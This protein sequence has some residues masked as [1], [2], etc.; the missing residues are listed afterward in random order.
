MHIRF[1]YYDQMLLLIPRCVFVWSLFRCILVF[2]AKYTCCT[3]VT[4]PGMEPYSKC[5]PHLAWY[6]PLYC[7][8]CTWH[9]RHH[10]PTLYILYTS[11]LCTRVNPPCNHSA[12]VPPIVMCDTF[13]PLTMQGPYPPHIL[14]SHRMNHCTAYTHTSKT[15]G[16]GR[17]RRLMDYQLMEYHPQWFGWLC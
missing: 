2:L 10:H 7:A 14:R 13:P 15:R 8:T 5:V 12:C 17:F 11:H 9:S 3:W 4:H 6:G 1:A 16:R